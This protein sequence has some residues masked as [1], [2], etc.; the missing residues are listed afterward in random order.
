M[1]RLEVGPFG[2][3]TADT[4]WPV[5]QWR[6]T[7]R[8]ERARESDTDAAAEGRQIGWGISSD[9]PQE[10]MFL[11]RV[12]FIVLV[13]VVGCMGGWFVLT[14]VSAPGPEQR[15]LSVNGTSSRMPVFTVELLRFGASK[16]NEAAARE[17]VE[18]DDIQVVADSQEFFLRP[19][20]EGEQALCCGRFADRRTAEEVLARF[21]EYT[22]SSR[23][24]FPKAAVMSLSD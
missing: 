20:G 11:R 1:R 14:T 23:R 9:D 15:T 22:Q 21:Q 10:D 8:K 17:L 7:V 5:A 18:L 16:A 13:A 3:R 2:V 12:L 4:I 19:V 24:G 6:L